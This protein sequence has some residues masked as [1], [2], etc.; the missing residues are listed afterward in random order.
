MYLLENKCRR[1]NRNA[2]RLE[3]KQEMQ[4]PYVKTTKNIKV[5]SEKEHKHITFL[6]STDRY[7]WA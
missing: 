2:A 1:C 6:K 4:L 3:M 5:E 7:I